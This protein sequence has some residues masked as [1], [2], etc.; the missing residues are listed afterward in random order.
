MTTTLSALENQV[1]EAVERL[2]ESVVSIDSVRVTRDFRYGLV[3]IEGKGSGLIIDR[4]GYV[5]T[6]NHVIDGATR[7]QVHLKDGR[8]FLGE[9]VGSDASTD[10]AVIKV[11]ADN[12]PAASLGDSEKLKVGQI[13][14]AIGNTLGLQGGPTVSMGVVSALGRPLPGTDFIFEGLI[15]TDTAINPG[16]SGGPLADI[17]GNVIGMNTAMIPFAQ[18]VGFAIPVNTMKWVVQQILEK[19]RVIRP[20]LG[21]SGANMNQAIAR[22]Y[23]LPADSGVLVVEVDSRG[24]AYEAGM[25]VGDVIIQIGSHPVKQMKDI[26]MA[27]SKLAIKEEVE[28]GFIRLNAKRKA[29]LRLKESPIAVSASWEG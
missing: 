13:A 28:V 3:P 11:D 22:R 2:S 14:L 17:G 21:I 24:P 29:L 1:T 19:G 15:Q 4:N 25:R 26:L 12:L 27:L 7:V 18:G 8:T 20:W 23:D 16:N 6:N 5:I 9:V 10:V